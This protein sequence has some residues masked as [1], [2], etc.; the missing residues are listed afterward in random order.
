MTTHVSVPNVSP[1]ISVTVPAG[2]QGA[3][4]R[5]RVWRRTRPFWAGL[6]TMVGGAVI[7]YV[8]ATAFRFM[9]FGGTL[10][11]AGITVGVLVAVFGLFL[12]V[13]PQYRSLLG[14][15]IVVLS[16]LSF[17]TSDFGGFFIG[18][19]V[20]MVGGSM[21]LAWTVATPKASDEAE[22]DER[23]VAEV[24]FASAGSRPQAAA[25]VRS[26]PI[27]AWP[28]PVTFHSMKWGQA[29]HPRTSELWRTWQGVYPG[30]R[31]PRSA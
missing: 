17:F 7:A 24:D 30:Y 22:T 18:M 23:R 25:M 3:R 2:L 16:L 5:F 4:I 13:Q 15:L 26:S 29:A 19:L 27:G 9:M 14:V 31:L 12:W 8:P 21:A 10:L 20:A 6:W 1:G 28:M 11:W